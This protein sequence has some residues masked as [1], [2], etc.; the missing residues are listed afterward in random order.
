MD[1]A[2][3]QYI[4][5]NTKLRERV[6]TLERANADLHSRLD[7]LRRAMRAR[8]FGFDGDDTEYGTRLRALRLPENPSNRSP[9]H[10]HYKSQAHTSETAS[11]RLA[12]HLTRDYEELAQRH[13]LTPDP[14]A[15]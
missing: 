12:E 6:A 4:D 15:S 8:P 7:E 2:T 3:H 1:E 13:N 9:Q 14:P 5:E 11:D 10:M